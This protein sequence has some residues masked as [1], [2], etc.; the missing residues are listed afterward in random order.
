M[1]NADDNPD[2][3]PASTAVEAVDADYPSVE[4]STGEPSENNAEEA[5]TP[6]DTSARKRGGV[7]GIAGLAVSIVALVGVV[8]LS[9][10]RE[11]LPELDFAAPA[12]LRAVGD[13]VAALE[14]SIA[15]LEQRLDSLSA[16]DVTATQAQQQLER[17]LSDELEAL[18]GRVDGFDSLAPR[19]GNLENAV[20][21]IQGIE[22]GARDTLLLA[23]AEYYL[24]IANS[25]LNLAGNAELAEVALGMA[26]DRLTAIGNPALD[27]VRQAITDEIT[28]LGLTAAPDVENSAMLLSSL[29]RLVDSLPLKTVDGNL[30]GDG[31]PATPPDE[32]PGA[33]GRAWNAVKEAVGG[34]V[35]ITPPGDDNA[36]L[37]VPGTE[38]L[39]R[40]N[41][42]LQLQAAR[43]AL[44]KGEQTLFEQ[45]LDD[46]ADWLEQYFDGASLQVRSAE[47]TLSEIRESA[48]TG[49]FPDI[50][51]SLRLLR[52]YRSLSD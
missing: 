2:K 40:A 4:A 16:A 23:E 42:S 50:S 36:P 11:T 31:A 27:N 47:A 34:A 43:L 46:A 41:L 51:E 3:D 8:W 1:S 14:A 28:A 12:D 48:V 9:L 26:N 37:L 32:Q 30:I 7:M 17:S 19:V 45:S 33:M 49:D 20:A 24:R 13:S 52:Q 5:D 18:D 21:A 29:A 10:S 15:D 35:T 38:P 25:L 44:L 39:I 22:A 6:R